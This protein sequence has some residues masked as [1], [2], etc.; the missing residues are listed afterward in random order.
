MSLQASTHTHT[1][2]NLCVRIYLQD[3][4]RSS[5]FCEEANSECQRIREQQNDSPERVTHTVETV[6][7]SDCSATIGE[8]RLISQRACK[9]NHSDRATSHHPSH[10]T[11]QQLR[12]L[13]LPNFPFASV[14][15]SSPCSCYNPTDS[16]LLSL[17]HRKPRTV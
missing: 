14:T 9:P 3:H 16:S 11:V 1:H 12:L 5:R 4:L 17:G 10:S 13:F 15:V 6:I 2:T 8:G 7:S